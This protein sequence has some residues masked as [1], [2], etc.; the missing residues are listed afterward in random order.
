MT[1]EALIAVPSTKAADVAQ[2]KLVADTVA[3]DAANHQKKINYVWE[4]TQAGIAGSVVLATLI[5]EFLIVS[6]FSKVD[7]E[8]VL[9]AAAFG[10][11]VGF[12]FGRTNH[13]RPIK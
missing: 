2:A 1:D 4:Y 10:L 3:A 6:G 5:M 13:A 9:I 7:K 12:Y 11:V 8:P